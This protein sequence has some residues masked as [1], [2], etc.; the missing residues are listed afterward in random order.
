MGEQP[1]VL[2]LRLQEGRMTRLRYA[3]RQRQFADSALS[4]EAKARL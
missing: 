2:G 3:P 4:P 1:V